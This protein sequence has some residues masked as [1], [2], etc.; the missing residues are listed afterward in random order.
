MRIC[1][2]FKEIRWKVKNW[3]LLLMNKCLFFPKSRLHRIVKWP[4]RIVKWLWIFVPRPGT[5]PEKHHW[6][7]LIDTSAHHSLDS[8]GKTNRLQPNS[9]IFSLIR[10]GWKVIWICLSRNCIKKSMK[11]EEIIGKWMKSEK[12]AVTLQPKYK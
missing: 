12:K 11:S 1:L 8:T 2:I 5:K 9:L 6:H 7:K 3:C 4:Y 10:S